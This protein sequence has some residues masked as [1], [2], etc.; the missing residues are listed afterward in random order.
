VGSRLGWHS[1]VCWPLRG[2]R[3]TYTQKPIKI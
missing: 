1:T 2:G 3:G